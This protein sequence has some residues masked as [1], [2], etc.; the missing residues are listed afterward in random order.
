[1]QSAEQ[2]DVPDNITEEGDAKMHRPLPSV[3][4]FVAFNRV[5]SFSIEAV[6]RKT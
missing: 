4:R 5:V 3:V 2:I 6:V 1:M